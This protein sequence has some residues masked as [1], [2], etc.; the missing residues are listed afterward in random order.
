[1]FYFNNPKGRDCPTIYG[2]PDAFYDLGTTGVQAKQAEDIK[3]GDECIVAT[4]EGKDRVLFTRVT[5]S[6][7][8]LMPDEHG[9]RQRVLFGKRGTRE[10]LSKADASRHAVYSKFFDKNGNFK[11]QS[12]IQV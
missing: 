5:F 10:T 9:Q 3:V 2:R 11:R 7:E 4:V 12:T 6:G 8:E 1:V